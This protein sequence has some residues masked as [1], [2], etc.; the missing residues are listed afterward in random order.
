MGAFHNFLIILLL[1]VEAGV[2]FYLERKAWNTLYT[3]LNF[4]MLPYIF[5]LMVTI[6]VSGKFDFV[7]FYYP[8]IL[9]WNIGLLLFAVP[10][11]ALSV[12][13]RKSAGLTNSSFTGHSS[14]DD[15]IPMIFVYIGAVIALLFIYRLKSTIGN[16][17]FVIGSDEFAEEF[18]GFGFWGHLKRFTGVLLMMYIYFLNRKQRW[19]WLLIIAFMVVS[20][21]NMVKGTMIIPCVVGVMMRLASGKMRITGRFVV[22]LLL[23]SVAVF[24]ITFLLAIVVV[25]GM[26]VD[27]NVIV[28]ILQRFVH[29]FTSGTL[30][31]SMDMQ[32]DFPDRGEFDIVMTPFINII[33]QLT[34]NGELLSPIN[35]VYHYTGISLTNVRTI[36]G[37]LYI[38]SN[39]SQ[40]AIYV[41]CLSLVCYFL[42]I[43]SDKTGNTFVNLVFFYFCALLAMGWFEF[44]F[45]HL[46]VIE[47]PAMI[48]FLHV[49][50]WTL[51]GRKHYLLQTENKMYQ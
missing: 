29:Y 1:L 14:D 5:V 10:D 37:T 41:M 50:D 40:F 24:F 44:Y 27:D 13:V 35:A 25:N 38:Y 4:L 32:L 30:G 16:S 42:K 26:E 31:L 36:F 45:F 6:A 34:G 3:P 2:L 39:Y 19:L 48:I 18:A 33:N 23:S 7:E 17:K 46:D 20:V 51:V 47:I 28:Y 22:I 49:V 11:I 15:K 21:I 9:L 43:I 12:V 8:S